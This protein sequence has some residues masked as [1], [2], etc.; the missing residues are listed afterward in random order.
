MRSC[1]AVVERCQATGLFVGQV[2]GFLGAQR[3]AKRKRGGRSSLREV[4]RLLLDDGE[5][6]ERKRKHRGGR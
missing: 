3:I 2:P 5:P 4:V 6:K 1:T